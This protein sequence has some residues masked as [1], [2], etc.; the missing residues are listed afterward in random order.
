METQKVK[1]NVS[2]GPHTAGKGWAINRDYRRE[3]DAKRYALSISKKHPEWG[4]P[5]IRKMAIIP[6]PGFGSAWMEQKQYPWPTA[7]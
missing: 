7:S 2:A 5:T 6:F 1:W 4:T 3:G